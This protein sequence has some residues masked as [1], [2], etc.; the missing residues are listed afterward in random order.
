MINQTKA[1]KLIKL[2]QYVCD[3]YEQ[4]LKYTCERFS[5][6]DK[7]EFTDQEI[8][9]IYLFSVH[10]EQKFKVKEIHN[11]ASDYLRSWFPKLNSYVAFNT[12]LNRLSEAITALCRVVIE[13]FIPSGCSSEFSLLDS[14]PIIT[15]SGKRSAKVAKKSRIK[16]TVP[17]KIYGTMG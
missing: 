17:L 8:M 16:A 10:E 5:N 1:S 13:E 12:R 9:T 11:F 4:E 14:M 6:N 7:P 3:K 15:C 2:Y